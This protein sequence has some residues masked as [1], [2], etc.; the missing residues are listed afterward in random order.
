MHAIFV[1]NFP[2]K[3]ITLIVEASD[4]IDN[5]KS[6][7]QDKISIPADQ[8]RL[9]FASKYLENGHTLAEYKVRQQATIQLAS[10]LVGGVKISVTLRSGKDITLEV[11]ESET[12]ADLKAKIEDQ[13]GVPAHQYCLTYDGTELE[14]D[15]KLSSY[16]FKANAT[17]HMEPRHLAKVL[18]MCA[19]ADIRMLHCCKCQGTYT[20]STTNQ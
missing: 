19:R 17:L 1:K 15:R 12:V 16:K 8:Q 2:G 6:K 11:N 20:N 10:S 7:I 3:A 18:H 5:V 4:T 9:V 14:N 13:E